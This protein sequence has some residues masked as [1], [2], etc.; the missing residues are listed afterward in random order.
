MREIV[1]KKKDEMVKE[2]KEEKKGNVLDV[3]MQ[4]GY[5][6][7]KKVQMRKE[8]ERM[9]VLKEMKK[10]VKK[11]MKEKKKEEGKIIENKKKLIGDMEGENN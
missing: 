11:R 2:K 5:R 10:M 4:M 3:G 6:K 1:E 9:R 8:Y 7:G